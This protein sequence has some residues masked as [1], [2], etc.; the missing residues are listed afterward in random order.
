MASQWDLYLGW[1]FL[2][3]RGTVME[4]DIVRPA[5][6]FKAATRIL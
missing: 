5:L 2:P 3:Y 6:F 4:K 1:I